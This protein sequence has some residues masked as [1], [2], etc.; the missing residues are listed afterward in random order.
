M[1]VIGPEAPPNSTGTA[2][3]APPSLR[4]TTKCRCGPVLKPVL[5]ESARYSPRRTRWPGMTRIEFQFRCTYS[6]IVP[7]SCRTRTMLARTVGF[8]VG[9]GLEEIARDFDDDAFA[10]CEHVRADRHR[11]IDRVLA[12]GIRVGLH[13]RIRLRHAGGRRQRIRQ[14]VRLTGPVLDAGLARNE[15][16]IR[17]EA[18]IDGVDGLADDDELRLAARRQG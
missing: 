1:S 10:R 8:V 15:L 16:K 9:A 18:Q 11:E 17:V 5:P 7:S 3:S 12:A 4:C 14:A 6:A 13:D 2:T